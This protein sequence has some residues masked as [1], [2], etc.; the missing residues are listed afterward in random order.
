MSVLCPL[1]DFID[2]KPLSFNKNVLRNDKEYKKEANGRNGSDGSSSTT[3]NRGVGSGGMGAIRK[4][5]AAGFRY[6]VA[7]TRKADRPIGGFS[8][9][10]R[11]RKRKAGWD[12][13]HFARNSKDFRTWEQESSEEQRILGF[14]NLDEKE[15]G[16]SE[17]PW[18]D[19]KYCDSEAD[20]P[21][22]KNFCWGGF[23]SK[24]TGTNLALK[25]KKNR[26]E[27]HN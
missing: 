17:D 25:Y 20:C 16:A 13:G 24:Y 27:F 4:K 26:Q 12:G 18:E 23:C 8:G 3:Q 9:G 2:L 5:K 14:R 19:D 15:G 22:N 10:P 11:D 7:P 21:R 1:L 6:L